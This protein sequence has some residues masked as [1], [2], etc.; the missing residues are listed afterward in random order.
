MTIR[1][2]DDLLKSVGLARLSKVNE[3]IDSVPFKANGT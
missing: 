2:F 1:T 3:M